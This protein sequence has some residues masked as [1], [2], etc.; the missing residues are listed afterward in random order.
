M[1]GDSG[2]GTVY[3][4]WGHDQ[5]PLTAELVYTGRMGG[6]GRHQPG[7]GTNPQCLPMDPSYL[8]AISGGQRWRA[9]I[10]G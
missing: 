4:R 6:V 9:T 3:V 1:K 2:G 7:G 10:Y 5:C 8:T